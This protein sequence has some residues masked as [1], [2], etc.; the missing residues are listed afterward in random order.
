VVRLKLTATKKT[1]LKK[2]QMK[3]YDYTI[4]ITASDEAQ[5]E[6]KMKALCVLAAKLVEKELVKLADI[7]LNDPVKTQLAKRALGV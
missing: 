6:R 7:I 5:A 1:H 2:N 3:K 4:S